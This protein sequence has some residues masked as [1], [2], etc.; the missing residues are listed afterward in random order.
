MGT[1]QGGVMRMPRERFV[2]FREQ[3]GFRTADHRSIFASTAGEL[4]ILPQVEARPFI[5]VFDGHRFKSFR[6]NVPVNPGGPCATDRRSSGSYWGM[7]DFYLPWVASISQVN[8]RAT[9]GATRAQSDLQR[10]RIA[11]S[12]RGRRW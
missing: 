3:D 4:V 1:R 9:S 6:I 10:G 8:K 12:I 7:V 2:T 5:Q 11:G